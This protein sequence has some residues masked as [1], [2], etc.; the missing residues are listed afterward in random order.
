MG[1]QSYGK[2]FYIIIRTLF[3]RTHSSTITQDVLS[4]YQSE[5]TIAV[6]YF[7]FDFNDSDK[8]R[9]EKLIRSLIVQLSAQC[10]HLPASL[11]LAYSRSQNGQNQLT[12][13][14]LRTLLHQVLES[15]NSTYIL[16]DALDECTDREDLLE[17][18]EALVDWNVNDLHVLATSRKENDIAMSLEPLVTCQLCIQSALVDA[19]IRVHI[20]DRLST[21]VKLKKWP[22]NV[23]KEV[24]DTLMRGAKGM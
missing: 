16:L 15:F 7:Y 11:Q 12:V 1:R 19:D 14:D 2:Y 5:P 22:T 20:L 13:E 24:E 6:A 18:M 3:D 17:F 10:L 9:T 21:D 23:Q 8:Q 4:N